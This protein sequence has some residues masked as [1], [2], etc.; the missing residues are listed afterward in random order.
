M[1]AV[2]FG[3]VIFFGK[4][5]KGFFDENDQIHRRKKK[6]IM[7]GCSTEIAFW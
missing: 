6:R 5:I 7:I 4:G 1:L 2:L 3:S